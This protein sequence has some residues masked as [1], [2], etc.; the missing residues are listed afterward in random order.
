MSMDKNLENGTILP[1]GLVFCSFCR[2]ESVPKIEEYIDYNVKDIFC[3]VC[4][5]R[6]GTV[7]I[8]LPVGKE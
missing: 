7:S 2:S 3:G 1:G 6:I 8:H 5:C 4:R